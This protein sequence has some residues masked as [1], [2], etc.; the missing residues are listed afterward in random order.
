MTG[1][2]VTI[3]TTMVQTYWL[4]GPKIVEAEQDG[5]KRAAYGK[6]V[7]PELARRL[8]EEFGPGFDVSNL[9]NMRQFY[10]CFPIRDAL[11]GPHLHRQPPSPRD[12]PD[13]QYHL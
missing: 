2:P 6:Q 8:G 11:P 10:L 9:R 13:I 1:Q 4:I 12:L 7:L 5:H 3:N